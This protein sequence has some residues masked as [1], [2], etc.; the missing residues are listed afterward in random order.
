MFACETG[1]GIFPTRTSTAH[2]SDP[3]KVSR[4]PQ[5][6]PVTG[7][8]SFGR[9]AD[10]HSH[11]ELEHRASS[12]EGTSAFP[13][14]QQQ[15]SRRILCDSG[16]ESPT[17]SSET[18]LYLPRGECYTQVSWWCGTLDARGTRERGWWGGSDQVSTPLPK[19]RSVAKTARRVRGL[20]VIC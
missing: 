16:S 20:T 6:L 9:F 7:A 12:F 1:L 19:S 5:P 11:K 10:D 14:N 15:A 17:D 18:G 13:P 3:C 8:I 4:G 2:S